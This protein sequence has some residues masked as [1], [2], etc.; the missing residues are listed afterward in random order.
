MD[1]EIKD[2]EMQKEF[3]NTISQEISRLS[4]FIQNLLN[5]SKIE[6][7]GLTLNKGFV[8]TDWLASDCI[9]AIEKAAQEKQI[10]VEKN[11]PDNFPTLVGDKELLKIAMINLLSNAVKYTPENGQVTFALLEE[12]NKVIF[13][14]ADTGCGISEEEIPMVFNKFY[15]SNNPYVAEQKGNG[16]GLAMTSDIVHLHGGNIE[17]KSELNEGSQFTIQLPIEEYYLGKQ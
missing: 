6:M 14:V 3:Y 10:T 13:E 17:V 2:L 5:M 8:K 9:A 4:S 15:R 16:L 12:D 1:G 11:L 7:G